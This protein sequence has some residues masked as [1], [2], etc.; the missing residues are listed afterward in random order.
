[1][2]SLSLQKSVVVLLK[3]NLPSPSLKTRRSLRN[4]VARPKVRLSQLLKY[5]QL[6]RVEDGLRKTLYL[7]KKTRQSRAVEAI[8][9]NQLPS[10]RRRPLH[11]SVVVQ[12][13]LHPLTSIA[14]LVPPV[15][16]NDLL[17]KLRLGLLPAASILAFVP[18][19]APACLQPRIPL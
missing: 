8:L 9:P 5:L 18:S 14:L 13:A 3:Q 17:L 4:V 7:H 10:Q 1:M 2:S 15:S 12:R 6:R 11:P 19:C 16:A